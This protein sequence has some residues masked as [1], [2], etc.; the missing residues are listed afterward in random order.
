M[1]RILQGRI[2]IISPL[3]V[4]Q[5]LSDLPPTLSLSTF[6]PC[7]CSV[8]YPNA[9]EIY[10]PPSPP[11]PHLHALFVF[12]VLSPSLMCAVHM[13]LSMHLHTGVWS[14][15]QRPHRKAN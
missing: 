10:L 5:L 13:F 14:A 6:M 9:S 1:L 11:L 3:L 12:C 8:F 2:L 4:P 15:Y 7:L